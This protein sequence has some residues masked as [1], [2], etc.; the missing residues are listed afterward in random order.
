MATTKNDKCEKCKYFDDK[1]CK[2]HPPQITLISP[3]THGVAQLND[4]PVVQDEDWCGEFEKKG[5][6]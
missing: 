3:G 5:M 2:R 4:W 6:F 1:R